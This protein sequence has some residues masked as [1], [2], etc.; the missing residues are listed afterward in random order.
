VFRR[1][2]RHS[3][4]ALAA[5]ALTAGAAG[6]VPTAQA[7]YDDP[8]TKLPRKTAPYSDVGP[9][10]PYVQ[11]IT[12]NTVVPLKNEAIINRT[13]HGYLFRAGQQNT[14]LTVTYTGGRVRF[15]DTGTAKWKWLPAAC[16]RVAVPKGVGATC[17]KQAKFTYAAPM[18]LEIWPRLGNDVVDTTALPALFDVS[19]LGDKGDDVAHLGA[20]N[21]FFN[22][23][24][25]RDR[26]YGGAG[27]DWIRT[28][29]ADDHIAGGDGDDYLAGVDG[30]DTIHGNDGND[31]LYGIAGNDS[32]VAGRGSDQVSCGT[33][34][35]SA[36]VTSGDRVIGCES[37]RTS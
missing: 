29:L 13:A 37:T 8:T 21:D 26:G 11:E 5:A 20:G 1:R 28:G 35:D 9:K 2:I 6:M 12:I 7:G 25:D 14:D 4:V 17:A 16:R 33:G 36:S 15:V 34:V 10:R 19:F 32:I 30:H 23:A 18:L 3:L 27:N 24:Q 22:G 31:R